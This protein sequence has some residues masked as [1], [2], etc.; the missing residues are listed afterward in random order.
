MHS[1]NL[2]LGRVSLYSLPAGGVRGQP[3][4]SPPLGIFILP[5][6]RG[7]PWPKGSWRVVPLGLEDG[8]R[9]ARG[10]QVARV[11]LPNRSQI[12]SLSDSDRLENKL[13]LP[14]RGEAHWLSI[15]LCFSGTVAPPTHCPGPFPE[16][17]LRARGVS[18]MCIVRPPIPTS[19]APLSQRLPV[20]CQR[21]S[22]AEAPPVSYADS[23]RSAPKPAEAPFLG[24]QDTLFF[25][26]IPPLV[27]QVKTP[28]TGLF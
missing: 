12:S 14:G 3:E 26:R 9:R 28:R 5:A 27:P 7:S 16:P 19:K 23:R 15:A 6:S 11:L 10:H 1:W 4:P 13:N 21:R 18:L 25:T 17:R 24:R 22:A 2:H 8:K 20:V